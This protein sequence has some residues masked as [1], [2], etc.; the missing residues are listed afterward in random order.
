VDDGTASTLAAAQSA[1]ARG[2]RVTPLAERGKL[3]IREGWQVE[4]L[5]GADVQALWE[6]RPAA[7]VGIVTGPRGDGGSGLLVIDLDEKNEGISGAAS[8]HEAVAELGAVP[9][10][11]VVTTPSGGRHLYFTYPDDSDG[12]RNWQGWRPGIDVRGWHGFVVGAGSIV[13]L[14]SYATV[15]DRPPAALPEAWLEALRAKPADL[16][17]RPEFAQVDVSAL[18][19]STV[20]RM[21]QAAAGEVEP[22][23][24]RMASWAGPG[25]HR[26]LVECGLQ[27][28]SWSHLLDDPMAAAG[29]L[30]AALEKAH[31]DDGT[32][33]QF[34]ARRSMRGVISLMQTGSTHPKWPT[35]RGTS[36]G[37]LADH[38]LDSLRP[39]EWTAPPPAVA[40]RSWDDVGNAER[41]IDFAGDRFAYATDSEQWLHYGGGIWSASSAPTLL[42]R[43][44]VEMLEH[45]AVVE[46]PLYSDAPNYAT[47]A[48]GNQGAPKP[49]DRENFEGFISRSRT[50]PKIAAA[51]TVATASSAVARVM[52]DFDAEPMLLCIGNGVLDLETGRLREHDSSLLMT[53]QAPVA[54]A[55]DN[56]PAPRWEAF[57]ARVQPDEELRD[58][59]ARAIGY[60]LTGS[61]AEQVMFLHFGTG[62]NG[63]SVFVDTV[64][65]VLGSYAQTVPRSALLLKRTDGIPND[66]ARMRGKR[67]LRTSE[68]KAGES[69]DMGLIKDL[70]GG[71]ELSARHMRAEFFDF[72]PVAKIHLSTNHLP[73][74]SSG[75]SVERR[76]R[77]IEW[78]AELDPAE[79]DP[80]LVARL[81]AEEL[82][83]VLAWAYRGCRAWLAAGRLE[84]PESV[85]LATSGH[86][87]ASDPLAEWLEVRVER[88][89][90]AEVE[91][92]A[93]YADYA[94]WS[95]ARGRKPMGDNTLAHALR[96]RKFDLGKDSKTRRSILRD[97][98]LRPRGLQSPSTGWQRPYV[99]ADESV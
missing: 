85:T 37:S 88:V 84:T 82:P 19:P 36:L 17:A 34:D 44:T 94:E 43:A 33:S 81:A 39:F 57:L 49:S 4:A 23:C 59:L 22:I 47:L 55:G 40:V 90:G 11:H 61:T 6:R 8:M 79:V 67:L 97:A 54:W 26:V 68:T 65:R 42:R 83:G 73:H 91:L 30:V 87:M 70:T 18:D 78:A 29:R 46:A 24:A 16:A 20:S 66:I 28:G 99:V 10:T 15:A 31:A 93:V 75:N 64:V 92:A 51:G 76:L 21:R 53:Q 45:V 74:V 56:A 77:D 1:T 41:L 58:Y 50:A 72:R 35:L 9:R 80:T 98:S 89:P 14:G 27:L 60:T 12:W 69:L 7:N 38:G 96:E 52:A 95:A 13:S 62:G 63:K 32:L 2:W 71:E 48:S 3:P 86:I 5:S 25:K